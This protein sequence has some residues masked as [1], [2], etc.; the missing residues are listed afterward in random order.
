ML[1]KHNTIIYTVEPVDKKNLAESLRSPP[2]NGR[3]LARRKLVKA[4]N[5]LTSLQMGY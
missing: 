4:Y 3:G 1:S 2:R 5:P